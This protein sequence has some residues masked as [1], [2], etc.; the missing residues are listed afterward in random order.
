MASLL[1]GTARSRSATSDPTVSLHT[2]WRSSMCD[3][4]S[5]TVAY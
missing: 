3:F 5:M 2:K 1:T 4:A